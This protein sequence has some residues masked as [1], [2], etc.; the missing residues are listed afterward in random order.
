MYLPT[1]ENSKNSPDKKKGSVIFLLTPNMSSSISLMNNPL[2]VN[3][4]RYRGYDIEKDLTYY[5]GAKTLEKDN[6]LDE[7][8]IFETDNSELWKDKQRILFYSGVNKDV[9]TLRKIFDQDD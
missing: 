9:E 6:S 8:Y 7:A 3:K 1:L 5:I 4:L 2:L